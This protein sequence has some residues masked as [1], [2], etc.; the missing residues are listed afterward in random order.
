MSNKNKPTKKPAQPIPAIP[1]LG[2]LHKPR[3]GNKRAAKAIES[4]T[5]LWDTRHVER[6]ARRRALA[7]QEAE[8][9]LRQR[10]RIT[11]DFLDQVLARCPNWQPLSR[12]LTIVPRDDENVHVEELIAGA[13]GLILRE[14]DEDDL[15]FS[16]CGLTYREHI[17][18]RAVLPR[19]ITSRF[20]FHERTATVE[21][22]A[23]FHI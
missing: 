5:R 1:D 4:G 14:T 19:G 18:L 16:V 23:D 8:E 10:R 17:D 6:T 15:T 12:P 21:N 11:Q 2:K 3:K 13:A 22:H 9:R 20:L 7:R